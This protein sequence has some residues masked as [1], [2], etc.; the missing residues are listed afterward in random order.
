MNKLD[1]L[2]KKSN[3][4]LESFLYELNI[5]RSTFWRI[6]KGLRPLRENEIDKLS[7]L[8]KVTKQELKEASNFGRD[9]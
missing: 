9:S 7:E 4:K 3:Y 5:S 1:L 6:R 8:L 2:I